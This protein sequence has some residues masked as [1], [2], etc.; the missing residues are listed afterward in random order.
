MIPGF[1]QVMGQG[2]LAGG[3]EA[4]SAG[5]EAV[6]RQK[7][8]AVRRGGLLFRLNSFSVQSRLREP[9]ARSQYNRCGWIHEP[10]QA[11]NLQH[12]NFLD[13]IS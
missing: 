6:C 13:L 8:R 5:Q 10:L 4:E 7:L 12:S 3:D 2:A 9:A 11:H 1:R